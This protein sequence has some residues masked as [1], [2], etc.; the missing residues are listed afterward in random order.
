M[1][2]PRPGPHQRVAPQNLSERY[3]L[4][5]RRLE[6]GTAAPGELAAR[7]EAAAMTERAGLLGKLAGHAV[8]S[9]R[10]AEVAN[11]GSGTI[12]QLDD[13]LHRAAREYLT[14]PPGT[15]LHR[16]GQITRQVPG[17]LQEHRRLRHARDLYVIGAKCCAFLA[18]A[19]GDPGR[20]AAG[21]AHGC[22][23]QSRGDAVARPAS[24]A[25]L[26]RRSS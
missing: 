25:A 19:A 4:L 23:A 12:E 18:W 16:V 9:G 5:Y 10:W 3:E 13:A 22:A 21:T 2:K 17:L 26:I 20:L 6:F 7:P 8:E 14:S 1:N 11:V 24:V 15:L